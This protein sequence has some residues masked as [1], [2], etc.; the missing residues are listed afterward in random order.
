MP[1]PDTA[2]KRSKR[3]LRVS[4]SF[5]EGEEDEE[6]EVNSKEAVEEDITVMTEAF[7]EFKIFLDLGNDVNTAW[8][9]KIGLLEYALLPWDSWWQNGQVAI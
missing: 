3:K 8:L 5:E 4:Q 7:V 6:L 1:E 2:E 9:E